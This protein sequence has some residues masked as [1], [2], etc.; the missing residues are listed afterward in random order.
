MF[1]LDILLLFYLPNI[2]F[3]PSFPYENVPCK[4]RLGLKEFFEIKI[5]QLVLSSFTKEENSKQDGRDG[6]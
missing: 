5:M 6:I 1:I 2:R 3:K 4:K